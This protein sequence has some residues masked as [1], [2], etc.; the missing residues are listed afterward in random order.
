MK[1]KE[2][3]ANTE[4]K[5]DSFLDAITKIAA[6]LMAAPSLDAALPAAFREVGEAI[7]AHRV[8]LLESIQAPDGGFLMSERGHAKRKWTVAESDA[9]QVLGEIIGA[10]IARVRN[11]SE[12]ADAKGIVDN[13]TTVLFRI[14]AQPGMPL[15]YI[16]KC[17]QVGLFAG[18]IPI[19]VHFLPGY[20]SPRRCPAS[21]GMV[22]EAANGPY[23]V[24][25]VDIPRPIC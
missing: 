21:R 1:L 4:R 17:F 16:R 2:V 9:L 13:S 24:L 12:L 6:D 7:A 15:T 10:S 23:P 11:T 22:R 3:D 5:Q 14:K 25:M 8:V 18:A 19:V 20:C